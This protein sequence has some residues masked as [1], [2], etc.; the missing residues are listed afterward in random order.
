MF[1]TNLETSKQYY[2]HF[3]ERFSS[4]M[5]SVA[6]RCELEW[7]RSYC[8]WWTGSG[9]K[10][11]H[12]EAGSNF[13]SACEA[14][15]KAYYNLGLNRLEAVDCGVEV[16]ENSP[17]VDDPYKNNTRLIQALRLYF[18]TFPLYDDFTPVKLKDGTYAIEYKFELK[19]PVL[20]PT[21]GKRLIYTGKLDGIYYTKFGDTVYDFYV[22]DEKTCS[23]VKRLKG[24]K[25]VD[26]LAEADMYSTDQQMLG[27][28]Y[29]CRE[30]GR[31]WGLEQVSRLNTAKIRRI[32][33]TKDGD[34]PYELEIKYSEEL[35][36]AWY[37]QLVAKIVRLKSYYME[38]E[39]VGG[40]ATD[41]FLPNFD[42]ACLSFNSRCGFTFA[43]STTNDNA[44]LGAVMQQRVKTSSLDISLKDYLRLNNLLEE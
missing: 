6:N 22:V 21:T 25:D 39:D 14:V 5:M 30:L 1:K 13:A 44:A 31:Q 29:C 41:F 8:Q 7:Y 43:C 28:I 35:I 34:T 32:P 19:L 3:P 9:A 23:S 15:R 38:H 11:I 42:K 37:K 24:T 27:Y 16:L 4:T 17:N 2:T 33:L 10:S 12:L 18:K 26:Y 40:L 20:H 36:A